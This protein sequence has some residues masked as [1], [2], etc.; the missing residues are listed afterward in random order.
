MTFA[1]VRTYRPF[2]ACT[3]NRGGASESV[4]TH[5][6]LVFIRVWYL[7]GHLHACDPTPTLRRLC[8]RWVCFVSVVRCLT[9][10][11][12]CLFVSSE[13]SSRIPVA[14]SSAMCTVSGDELHNNLP[15]AVIAATNFVSS[16]VS[17][18]SDRIVPSN[19]RA[20][21]Q[22]R[23]FG[24]STNTSTA[25]LAIASLVQLSSPAI[26]SREAHQRPTRGAGEW[27]RQ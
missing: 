19:V 8:V 21:P 6:L 9:A 17:I 16:M 1:P 10:A 15:S 24:F 7:F 26:A 18:P 22:T 11:I 3:L 14:P 23:G 25:N 13:P 5:L 2:A 20:A 12:H 4:S 27:G